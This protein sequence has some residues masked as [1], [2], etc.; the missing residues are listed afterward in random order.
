MVRFSATPSTI[1]TAVVS[2]ERDDGMRFDTVM[3]NFG[4][5]GVESVFIATQPCRIMGVLFA[6]VTCDPNATVKIMPYHAPP[7]G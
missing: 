1:P 4:V 5:D 3:P 6:S 2:M 7:N